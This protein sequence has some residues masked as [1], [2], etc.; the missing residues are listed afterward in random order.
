MKIRFYGGPR[1]GDEIDNHYPVNPDQLIIDL[2]CP[3]IHSPTNVQR[4]E[5]HIYSYDCSRK[6]KFILYKHSLQRILQ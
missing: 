4:K 2:I 5:R 3:A 6:G 1:D